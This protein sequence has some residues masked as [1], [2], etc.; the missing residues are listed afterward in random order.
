MLTSLIVWVVLGLVVGYLISLATGVN[1]GR[2]L[3]EYLAGGVVGSLAG[4]LIFHYLDLAGDVEGV[5]IVAVVAAL[6]AAIILLLILR[7]VRRPTA[8]A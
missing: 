3:L 6:V 8:T 5:D 1:R 2:S 4:G 7:N